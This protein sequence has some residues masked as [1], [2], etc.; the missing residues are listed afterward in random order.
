MARAENVCG[1]LAS[2]RERE[3]SRMPAACGGTCDAGE[4]KAG[5][6]WA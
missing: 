1:P 3:M 2:R 6:R 5:A 4:E